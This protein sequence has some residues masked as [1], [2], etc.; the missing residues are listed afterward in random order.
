MSNGLYL[1]SIF[2]ERYSFAYINQ[3]ARAEVSTGMYNIG[4]GEDQC[5][6]RDVIRPLRFYFYSLA[7]CEQTGALEAVE[8]C[9]TIRDW[10]D[11]Q[12]EP[13]LRTDDEPLMPDPVDP[14]MPD[15][16][17]LPMPDP[18]DPP[19]PE[20]VPSDDCVLD[21]LPQSCR[22]FFMTDTCSLVEQLI[23]YNNLRLSMHNE[24]RARH[25]DTDPLSFN[26][27]IACQATSYAKHLDITGSF[28]HAPRADR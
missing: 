16:V 21:D 18:V 2:A 1:E 19:M 27:D 28:S 20:P 4:P 7:R 12:L 25:E 14:P 13:C 6:I 24:R 8:R 11:L 23:Q 17:D 3:Q 9:E 22:D 10:K 15:P 26:L 5:S